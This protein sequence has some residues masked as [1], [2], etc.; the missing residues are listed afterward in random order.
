MD[1]HRSVL[2]TSCVLFAV[3]FVAMIALVAGRLSAMAP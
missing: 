3:T 1:I 2:I